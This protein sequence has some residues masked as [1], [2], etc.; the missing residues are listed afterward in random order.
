MSDRIRV[1]ICDDHGVV[2]GG[3][4]ALLSLE[5]DMEVVGEAGSA[6]EALGQVAAWRPDVVL[7]DITLPGMDGL[8]ATRQILRDAPSCRVLILTVHQQAHYLLEAVKAGASGY[9][10][11]S[12]LDVE[13][14][15]AI[16]AVHQGN[17]FIQSADTRVFFQAY[18]ESGGSVEG[19]RLSAMEQQVL[20]LTAQGATARE[21]GEVLVISPNSVGTYRRRIMEK[22]GLQG[23]SEL[24]KWAQDHGMLSY[25]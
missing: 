19:Q 4:R 12:D 23:R 13:L 20:R 18:L 22:L 7:M 17:V 15:G 16:R 1:A 11:K 2:R 6:E 5:P 25:E 3:L 9:V 21:I 24:V 14:L 8:E 10:A